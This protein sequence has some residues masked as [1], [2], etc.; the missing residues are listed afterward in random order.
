[1]LD[2]I[3]QIHQGQISCWV[4]VTKF[5]QA[6]KGGEDSIRYFEGAKVYGS[7][8]TFL[9]YFGLKVNDSTEG[10]NLQNM[11][12]RLQTVPEYFDQNLTYYST[13]AHLEI[14]HMTVFG[15]RNDD[16][17]MWFL[18]SGSSASK[19]EIGQNQLVNLKDM[20]V[21]LKNIDPDWANSATVQKGRLKVV[22]Y[23]DYINGTRSSEGD[24]SGLQ[25]MLVMVDASDLRLMDLKLYFNQNAIDMPTSFEQF[26][27]VLDLEDE[28]SERPEGDKLLFKFE[29]KSV[30]VDM[31]CMLMNV[32]AFVF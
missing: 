29:V 5:Q 11:F 18:E 7:L 31:K 13:N 1:M 27:R 2:S 30:S 12:T 26:T 10:P 20:S 28:Q 6:L 22:F 32:H 19:N 25:K 14:D 4:E 8:E 16:C 17:D 21:N 23:G 24:A 9:V 3:S 15:K